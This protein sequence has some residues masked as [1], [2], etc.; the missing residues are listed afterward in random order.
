MSIY[1]DA[2]GYALERIDVELFLIHLDPDWTDH[3]N[4]DKYIAFEQ[5]TEYMLPA[6]IELAIK[7]SGC[8]D[9]YTSVHLRNQAI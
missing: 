1:N 2:K 4:P 6:E 8:L 7:D 3:Y 5:I 9:D